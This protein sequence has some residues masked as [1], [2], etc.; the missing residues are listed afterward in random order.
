MNA[1]IHKCQGELQDINS[2]MPFL[3]SC[4]YLICCD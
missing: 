2:Y 3:T 4:D 1:H